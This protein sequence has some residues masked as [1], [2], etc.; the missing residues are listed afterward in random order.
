MDIKNLIKIC[1]IESTKEGNL[2]IW[3]VKDGKI[4]FDEIK[5]KKPEILNYLIKQEEQKQA[6][7]KA[8]ELKIKSIEGLTELQNAINAEL[9]YSKAFNRMMEDEY[10]DGV[11]PP[12]KPKNSSTELKQKYPRAA[13]YIKAEN[14]SFTN[15]YA[16]SSAGNRAKERIINGEDY[17]TVIT[18]MEKEWSNHCN[19][20]I[21]D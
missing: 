19:E 3:N 11:N 7:Y 13:A 17:N 21:W 20:H 12:S 10:N 18:E 9:S 8:R 16:K 4:H 15:H 14:W 5:A 1:K 2:K 6:A